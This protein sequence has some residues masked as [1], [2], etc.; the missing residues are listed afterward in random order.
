K[1][2][3]H[4]REMIEFPLKYPAVFDRLGVEPPR[5]V[6]LYGP[7]G[8]GK[9]LIARAVAAETTATFFVINGPE[10]LQKTPGESETHLR[11][12]FQEAQ[13][14]APSIIFIDELDALTP[15]RAE[16]SGE[17]ERRI[18]GQLLALMDG[19]TPRELVMVLGATSRIDLLDPAVRRP[20]RF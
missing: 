12:V 20:G 16:I 3:Q 5:G 15:K 14:R 9:T 19:L 13:R 17:V 11:D 10:V 2:L 18:I 1:E 8:T 4:L 6:L 7:P